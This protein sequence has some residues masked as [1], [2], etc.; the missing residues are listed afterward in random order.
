[1]KVETVRMHQSEGKCVHD[2]DDASASQVRI[3]WARGFPG[4]H[5]GVVNFAVDKQF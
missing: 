3:G 1:M 5:S 4:T 2:K